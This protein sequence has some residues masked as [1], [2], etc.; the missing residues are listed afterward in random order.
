[1][2]TKHPPSVAND[3][4]YGLL[5]HVKKKVERGRLSMTTTNDRPKQN[6]TKPHRQNLSPLLAGY[7]SATISKTAASLPPFY[8]GVNKNKKASS[9]SMTEGHEAFG[10]IPC[11]SIV[12]GSTNIKLA[13]GV[14]TN[15]EL[16]PPTVDDITPSVE[17]S[18]IN[19]SHTHVATGNALVD[20]SKVSQSIA[21]S[22]VPLDSSRQISDIIPDKRGN[23]KI[24]DDYEKGDPWDKFMSDKIKGQYFAVAVGRNE[25]SFGIYDDLTRFKQEIEGYP[26]SLYQSCESYTEAHQYLESYLDNIAHEKMEISTVISKIRFLRSATTTSHA[27]VADGTSDIDNHSQPNILPDRRTVIQKHLRKNTMS[28]QQNFIAGKTFLSEKLV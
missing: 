7:A 23:L 22:A 10:A 15:D 17:I 28:P 27:V 6:V 20:V 16:L 21:N 5:Q 2:P 4:G 19:D 8:D 25:H 13:S 26:T 9:E 24:G 11:E 18:A 14:T 1:M 3:T 12:A